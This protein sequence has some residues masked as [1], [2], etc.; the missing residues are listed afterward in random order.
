MVLNPVVMAFVFVVG[1]SGHQ[2][3][4]IAHLTPARPGGIA[5]ND[6]RIRGAPATTLGRAN[7]GRNS[8][9]KYVLHFDDYSFTSNDMEGKDHSRFCIQIPA[10]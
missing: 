8:Y 10:G 1:A 3:S 9:D 6:A 2:A 7:I 4:V 5:A